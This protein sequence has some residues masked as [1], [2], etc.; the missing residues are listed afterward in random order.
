MLRELLR[1]FDENETEA[2]TPHPSRPVTQAAPPPPAPLSPVTTAR[3]PSKPVV[4]PPPPAESITD[5]ELPLQSVLENLPPQLRS[6]MRL[7]TVDLTRAT[8]SIAIGKI[9]PQLALGVVKITFGELRHAAPGLFDV[10]QEY[11]SLPI[12]LPLNEVL[13]RLS[14][15][16]LIRNPAQKHIEVP[17]DI[18]GPFSERGEGVSISAAAAKPQ[19]STV[20]PM[21]MTTP[22]PTPVKASPPPVAPPP[23]AFVSRSIKPELPPQ[24]SSL[25]HNGN[26]NGNGNGIPVQPIIPTIPFQPTTPIAPTAPAAARPAPPAPKPMPV[27]PEPATILAPLAA[28]S[29]NWPEVLRA[30]IAQLI[31]TNA[32]VAL[33]V[34]MVESALKRGRV[35]FAWRNLRSWI[36]PMPPVMSIHDGLELELPLKVV[37]PLYLAGQGGLAKAAKA[38]QQTPLPAEIPNLFFGFPQPQPPYEIPEPPVQAPPPDDTR[39]AAKP[40]AEAPRPDTNYYMWVESD[41]TRMTARPPETEFKREAVPA[42]DFTSRQTT[43]KE[44]VSRAMALNGVAGALVAL[45]DGLMVASEIPSDLNA[46]TLAAFLPQIYGR[47]SQ[48]TRELRMGDLNNLNFTVGNVP[49][50][51]FRIHGVYFAAFGRAGEPLPTAQLALLAG[52]LDRKKQ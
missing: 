9:M 39:F 30:E 33:P 44:V 19:P 3:L 10:D 27:A 11:D 46:D 43:P 45:P 12:V 18:T 20:P 48:C 49:W 25:P 29:E 38:H 14:S 35:I 16:S 22:V 5:L 4:T 21:R 23:P 7:A 34:N 15:N 36:K 50:K 17:P 47:V 1:R 37:A 6:R 13:T 26:G 8:I 51:V 42:T 24:I 28:L 41:T 40:V 2:G 52:E 31:S 32:Q